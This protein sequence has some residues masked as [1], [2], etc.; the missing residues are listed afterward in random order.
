MPSAGFKPVIPASER[1]Q[2]HALD[3]AANGM[4]Y[5]LSTTDKIY[6]NVLKLYYVNIAKL[7]KNYT[8]EE[9]SAL[10]NK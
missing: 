1:P 7:F 4:V 10:L 6:W 9:N 3:C 8:K 2:T 5:D